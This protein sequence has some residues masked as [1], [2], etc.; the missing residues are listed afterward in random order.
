MARLSLSVVIPCRN[1]PRELA[2]ILDALVPQVRHGDEVV[3]VD[4]HSTTALIPGRRQRSGRWRLM[5]SAS[6]GPGNRSAARETGRRAA[7]GDVIVFL[8]GDM[9]PCPRF[10]ENLRGLHGNGSPLAVKTERFSLSTREQ[11][12][13]KAWCLDAVATPD[14]WA[15]RVATPL[16]YLGSVEL[17]PGEA[18][19]PRTRPGD[20]PG[21]MTP[22][23]PEGH[24]LYAASNA[25]S[26]DHTLVDR[27]GG[28]DESYVGW[29]EEDLDFSYRLHG[30]GAPILFPDPAEHY[31]VHLDHPIPP[32][33]R[34]SLRQNALRF[35][36]KF[37]EVLAVREHTY[38]SYGFS[39]TGVVTDRDGSCR[40][41]LVRPRPSGQR[42]Q[43]G[44]FGTHRGE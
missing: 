25:L 39:L 33:R 31:A 27:I 16:A 44:E 9:V 11:S 40:G 1:N 26:V 14:R 28:W 34:E 43:S 22:L 19:R 23:A 41:D 30:A 42:S 15:G 18:E 3:L 17:R 38:R 36:S 35:V 2:W 4:D 12:K 21:R 24:W 8:D 29:G 37:P 7:G 5:P 6:A 13:G 10:L 20:R 32:T